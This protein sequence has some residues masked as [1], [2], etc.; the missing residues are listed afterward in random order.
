MR[1]GSL[2]PRINGLAV[3]MGALGITADLTSVL[4][5]YLNSFLN[6]LDFDIEQNT[7]ATPAM[8][9]QSLTSAVHDA[10][11]S[12]QYNGA[13]SCPDMTSAI[14]SAV[15]TYTS[16]YVSAKSAFDAN[17][18]AGLI[19][20]PLPVSSYNITPAGSNYQAQSAVD[21]S[22]PAQPYSPTQVRYS[23][24]PANAL[25]RVTPQT[26]TILRAPVSN[27]LAPPQANQT[28]V[29][30]AGSFTGTSTVSANPGVTTVPTPAIPTWALLG[31]AALGLFLMM[32]GK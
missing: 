32:K 20:T 9:Q 6:N 18:E 12:A 31:A 2:T 29:S 14:N 27:V 25:D 22:P 5:S 30:N 7:A 13:T 15:A 3:G 28:P 10:C 8:V 26:A 24:Q 17:V 19:A 4:T 1:I 23:S 16:A 11:A 21:N